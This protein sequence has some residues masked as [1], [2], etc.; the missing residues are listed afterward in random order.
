MIDTHTH[1]GRVWDHWP[2]LTEEEMLRWMDAHDL[3]KVV[4]LPLES[5]E[6]SAFYILTRDMIAAA[7]RH[8]DRFIPFG[9]ID[10]RMA[11]RGK[12]SFRSILAEYQEQGIKGCGEVKI[13]LPIDDPRLQVLYAACEELGLPLLFHSD[14]IR[15][16]DD[17]RLSGL[18]RMLRM[19]PRLSFI[20]HAPGWWSCISADVQPA[21][22]GGYPKGPVVPGG[23][24]DRLLSAYPNLYADLSAGSGATAISRDM[25][26]GRRFL[27]KHRERLLFAT[28]YLSPVQEVPQWELFQHLELQPETRRMITHDN[29]V[30][31]LRL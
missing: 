9:V 23:P 12:E 3:E 11:V 24:C 20:A 8:P 6:S 27:E 22:L 19:F 1:L 16:T 4:L 26:H 17:H 7:R 5:P 10:A 30:R 28:D 14:N 25:E 21:Q 31:L 29:A 2:E 13:G 15:C 18:E